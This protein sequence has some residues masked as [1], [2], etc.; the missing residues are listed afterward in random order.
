MENDAYH[1]YFQKQSNKVS[2]AMWVLINNNV[3]TRNIYIFFMMIE[4]AFNLLLIICL[5]NQVESIP[6]IS[7]S[8]LNIL[9]YNEPVHLSIVAI[10]HAAIHIMTLVFLAILV[11]KDYSWQTYS[12][13]KLIY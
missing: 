8:T 5:Y 6:T 2:L 12:E 11:F 1:E 10:V 4:F 13:K 7:R 3:V 9:D